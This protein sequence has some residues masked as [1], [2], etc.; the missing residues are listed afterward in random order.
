MQF[1]KI[2]TYVI[3]QVWYYTKYWKYSKSTGGRKQQPTDRGTDVT[4]ETPE[5]QSIAEV[6]LYSRGRPIL[7]WPKQVIVK[8][9]A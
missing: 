3:F 5:C 1:G 2:E 4:Y 8:R 9:E 6:K 7:L